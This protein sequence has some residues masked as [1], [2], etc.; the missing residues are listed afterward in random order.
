[1]L[2]LESRLS[3][4]RGAYNN[5]S[6]LKISESR[7]EIVKGTRESTSAVVPKKLLAGPLRA[8]HLWVCKEGDSR[9]RTC[10][11]KCQRLRILKSLAK[12]LVYVEGRDFI[13]ERG[14]VSLQQD[15]ASTVQ[16]KKK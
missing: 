14:E 13:S 3:R 2:D 4:P 6:S 12:N 7:R 8:L 10:K 1:M 11:K 16:K 15:L 5:R 9:S